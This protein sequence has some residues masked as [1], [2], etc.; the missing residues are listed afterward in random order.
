MTAPRTPR[1]A[2][3]IYPHSAPCFGRVLFLCLKKEVI[4]Y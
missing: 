1:R 2:V 4:S 3:L